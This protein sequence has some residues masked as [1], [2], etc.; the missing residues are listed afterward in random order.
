MTLESAASRALVVLPMAGFLL[1]AL[2]GRRLGK[3]AHWIPVLAIFVVWVIAMALRRPG[4][5][6][7]APLLPGSETIARLRGPPVQLDP[8]RRLRGRRRL[9]RRRADRLPAHRGDHD[10]PARPRLLD[11]LHEPRPGL[12]ALL[13]LPQPVHVQHAAAR[14]GQQLPGRVRGLGAG[15]PVQLPAHRVLV[16]QALGGAGRQ[17]GVHR[18]PRR[19]R[20]LR[21]RDHAHLRQPRARSTSARSSTRIGDARPDDRS[22]SSRC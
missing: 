10:R 16:P 1:T 20:R 7:A 4:P 17:E 6:R 13:R 18:Q 22:R 14:P 15:R 2:I 5:D 12:L 21:A 9:R 8:G 19:R 3:Q 11:R